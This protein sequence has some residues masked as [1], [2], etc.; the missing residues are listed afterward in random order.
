MTAYGA[1]K[2]RRGVNPGIYLLERAERVKWLDVESEIHVIHPPLRE[3]KNEKIRRPRTNPA[4]PIS[5]L[6]ETR[7]EE[8]FYLLAPKIRRAMPAT[9]PPRSDGNGA[10]SPLLSP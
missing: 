6:A 2:Y 9:A 5:R 1:Q 7:G 10:G 4:G 8:S 3:N